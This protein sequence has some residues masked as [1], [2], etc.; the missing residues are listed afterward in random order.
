MPDGAYSDAEDLYK[1]LRHLNIERAHHV[2]LSRGAAVALELTLTHPELVSALVLASPGVSTGKRS[3]ELQAQF[4]KIDALFETGDL[5][6]AVELEVR[7]WVDG[8]HRQP[9]QVDTAIR[10]LVREMDTNI[11]KLDN[12]NAKMLQLEPP[13][14]ARLNEI[15][16]PPFVIVGDGDVSDIVRNARDLSAGIANAKLVTMPGLAHMLNMEQPEDFN[17]LVLD[18]LRTFQAK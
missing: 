10:E 12:P 3:E 9:D 18:F 11:F 15:N 6:Q 14:P 17:R 13:I 7:L 8:P 16:V 1:L 4:T 2:G 5:A